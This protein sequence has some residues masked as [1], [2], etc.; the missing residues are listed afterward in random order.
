MWTRAG[1]VVFALACLACNEGAAPDLVNL[2]QCDWLASEVGGE[3]SPGRVPAD[4][5]VAG[6]PPI[7]LHSLFNTPAGDSV[8]EYAIYCTFSIPAA[9]PEES[10]G[11]YLPGIGDNWAA[12]MNGELLHDDVHLGDSGAIEVRRTVIGALVPINPRSL[13]P[14]PNLLTLRILGEGPVSGKQSAVPG[15][16]YSNGFR[17]A[18]LEQ[19]HRTNDETF[20]IAL[21]LVCLGFGCYHLLLFWRRRSERYGLYFFLFSVAITTFS[22]SRT[23]YAYERVFDTSILTLLENVSLCLLLP[24]FMLFLDHYFRRQRPPAI[25]VRAITILGAGFS[26]AVLAV[27]FR[28]LSNIVDIWKYVHLPILLLVPPI[29]MAVAIRRRYPDALRMCLAMAVL[30]LTASWD[31]V[32]SI[33][34]LQ[35]MDPLFP[36]G[37]FVFLFLPV[38]TMAN[39]FVSRFNEIDRLNETL[40]HQNARL[41]EADQLKDQFLTTTS[42]ELRTPLHG[43]IG[44]GETLLAGSSG[45]LPETALRDIRTVIA[46]ARRLSDL[47]DEMLDFSQLQEGGVRLET[48]PINLYRA[49]ESVIEVLRHTVQD[50]ELSLENRVPIDLPPIVADE[51]RLQQILINLVGNAIKFTRAGTVSVEARARPD[52]LVEISVRD[53]GIG[54]PAEHLDSI[55]EPFRQASSSLTRRFGGYGLGLS[56]ARQLV[57][58]HGSKL[59]VQSTPGQ[60]S[61]FHFNLPALAAASS[62]IVGRPTLGTERRREPPQKSAPAPVSVGPGPLILAV[63][64]EPINLQVLEG[65]LNPVGYR[66]RTATNAQE[67]LSIITEG[68][69]PDVVLLDV[70]LSGMSG[71]ELCEF[72]RQMHGPTDLPIIIV[73]ARARTD[74]L[75]SGLRAGA[76]DYLRKPFE[77]MELLARVQTL[78]ELKRTSL[79]RDRLLT[80]EQELR[81][82]RRIQGT[83][84]PDAPPNVP[85][86]K[87]FARC[88][89]HGEVGGDIYDFQTME[90][91]SLG[92]LIADV[93]GH[94]IP[95]ALVAA[96]VKIAFHVSIAQS[97]HPARLLESM[98]RVLLNQIEHQFITAAYLHLDPKAGRARFARAGHVPMLHVSASNGRHKIDHVTPRGR[99]IGC[100]QDIALSEIE[101]AIQPGD[102]FILLTDGFTELRD[103]R[104]NEMQRDLLLKTLA[105]N[106]DAPGEQLLATVFEKAKRPDVHGLEDDA[107][108]IIVDSVRMG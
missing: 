62:P 81:I 76:N 32:N 47:V 37:F 104:G 18:D 94:G 90:D 5:I 79:D 38:A 34:N 66:V 59:T 77:R 92:I 26:I 65:L 46:S 51:N 56:I 105:L 107:A 74:D 11:L 27:P 60:G 54:I 41:Q 84:L 44:V 78:A 73:T 61:S 99:V 15:L 16:F 64:D 72:L 31:I 1:A 108:I 58:L 97:A 91:G 103:E 43:I 86:L 9:P 3:F 23:R 102:R 39:S 71:L 28:Y 49:A 55:F 88:F 98:N 70:M 83:L 17:I 53:T 89:P 48:R 13:H 10:L 14:G 85:G 80:L 8:G 21:L 40:D 93:T 100:F 50:G 12:Y 82:A 33:L 101:I 42:H 7:A 69:L 25:W 52:G 96:M 20:S 67:A 95:A 35:P 87:L 75:V 6:R 22:L 24:F 68:P 106:P 57:Q 4:A 2:S 36:Y 63:D 29:Y 45:E 19:L 30:Y